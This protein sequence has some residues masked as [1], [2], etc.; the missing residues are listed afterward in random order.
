MLHRGDLALA[1]VAAGV[2]VAALDQ[3]MVVTVLPSIMRDLHIPFTRLDD[4]AWVVTGYL[5]GYTVAMPLFGR[6]ADVHGRRLMFLVALAI[7]AG[8]S[9]L[10]VLSGG[11]HSL[12]AAR[13]VQA[14]GGGAVVPIAMALSADLLPRHR[15]A[16]AVGL[17]GAAGEA[18]GVLG[19][20]YGA[21][22]THLWGW[23]AIFLVNVPLTMLL[24]AACWYL[25]PRDAPAAR[26]AGTDDQD[27]VRVDYL[28]AAL[29]AAALAGLTIG[30]G[31]ST[32]TGAVPVRPWWLLGSAAAFAA[33][34]TWELRSRQPLVRLGLFRERSFAAANIANLAVGAALIVGMVEIPLYAYSLLGMSEISGGLLL[35]RMTV[36][37]PVGALV[38]GAVAGQVGYRVTGVVGFA[39]I[40]MGY[41]MVARWPD[42]PGNLRMTL[43]LLLTGLGFGLVIAPI[44]ASVIESVGARWTATGSALVTVMRMIGMMVGLASLSSWGLRHFNQLMAG[45]VL[46]F[47]T[48]DMTDAQYKVLTTA[49]EQALSG[50]LHTVYGRFFAIAAVVAALAIVPALFFRRRATGAPHVPFVPQ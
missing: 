18:G 7:F 1:V 13:I 10:C 43:D 2:F 20:L 12:V 50:A 44:G 24:A 30:L 39:V 48:G 21:A 47:Q 35:L 15:L 23:R 14:A 26:G 31:S 25:L 34:I 3:T 29:L 32:Q 6:I 38:G 42:V 41:L 40:A 33:F 36:M 4:A 19:P 28:G 45:N 37:I 9:V 49:Y 17:V 8:G 16:F 5:L 27:R 46:P 11:L 22:L